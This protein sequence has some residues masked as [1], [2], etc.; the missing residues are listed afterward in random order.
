M[1]AKK[2][3]VASV[4]EAVL[5]FREAP[6]SLIPIVEKAQMPWKEPDNYDDWDAIAAV[7]FDSIVMRSV[8]EADEWKKFDAIP[9]FRK[10]IGTYSNCS[11]L[12]SS[13]E[14]GALAF[15]CF[16]TQSAAFDTCLFARLDKA[17]G[18]L[19]LERRGIQ[20]TKFLL[21]G[22]AGNSVFMVDTINVSL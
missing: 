8:E 13:D 15:I 17:N 20:S 6:I 10:R 4:N 12:T 22:R 19:G 3:W 7:L 1:P 5:I 18:V 21:A 11:F 14:P 9:K 2:L 16:E